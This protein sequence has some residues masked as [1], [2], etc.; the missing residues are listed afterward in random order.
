M[1]F[2]T[3][4]PYGQIDVIFDRYRETSIKSAER[5]RRC[6]SKKDIRRSVKGRNVPSCW[7]SFMASQENKADLANLLSREMLAQAPPD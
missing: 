1:A 6:N 3:G 4:K 5:Q 2:Q 7:S